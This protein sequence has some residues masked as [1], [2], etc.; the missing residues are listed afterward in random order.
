[1]ISCGCV[2]ILPR[3]RSGAATQCIFC[4]ILMNAWLN[5]VRACYKFH[6]GSTGIHRIN[7]YSYVFNSTAI[8]FHFPELK[9]ER[10]NLTWL[11]SKD[12]AFIHR[13]F[14][15]PEVQK[16]RGAS[17][18]ATVEDASKQLWEWRKKFADQEGIR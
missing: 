17:P 8:P 10:T 9:T 18:F 7:L 13:L 12:R 14:S 1:M 5:P 6:V 15:D 11:S 2:N 3:R 16:F 4:R